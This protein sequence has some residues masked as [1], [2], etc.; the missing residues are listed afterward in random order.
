MQVVSADRLKKL[1]PVL[2]RHIFDCFNNLRPR[3]FYTFWA[4]GRKR[5]TVCRL[6]HVTLSSVRAYRV[7]VLAVSLM[8][9]CTPSSE[10]PPPDREKFAECSGVIAFKTTE[11]WGD[12]AA[13]KVYDEK[14]AI[15]YR[16]E[17]K[18][19]DFNAVRD[20]GPNPIAPLTLVRGEYAPEFR[21]IG[22]S[23]NWFR[24]IATESTRESEIKYLRR[25]DRMFEWKAWDH[26]FLRRYIRFDRDLN[27]LYLR[28]GGGET[29][30]PREGIEHFYGA[31]LEG[32]WL[33]VDWKERGMIDGRNVV[34]QK[35]G[36]IKWRDAEKNRVI[37]FPWQ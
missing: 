26:Y 11:S 35:S 27:P 2:R 37:A 31:K 6:A 36:W 21:C 15:W 20:N 19:P 8:L 1:K 24:V 22:S 14:G 12:D 9:A 17:F 18:R 13:V 4:F 28:R 23:P 5:F 34:D 10:I 16:A 30:E 33:Q 32:D 7:L 29:L 3:Q 25:N